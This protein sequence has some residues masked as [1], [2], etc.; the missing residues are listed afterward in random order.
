MDNHTHGH[1]GFP[2]AGHIGH[3]HRGRRRHPQRGR[4]HSRHDGGPSGFPPGFAG[5]G[6]AGFG[7]DGPAFGRGRGRGG[8]GR[9]GDVRAAILLLLAE[10]P[11]HG[12]Q[13][14]QQI[15]ERSEGVWKPSSGS[16]YPALAQLE[17]EGLVLIEKVAG[18]KTAR[19]TEDGAQYVETNKADLGVPWDDVRGAAGVVSVDLRSAISALMGAASQVAAVGTPGQQAR[20]IEVLA[21]ARRALYRVLSEEVPA[22]DAAA[23]GRDTEGED[24]SAGGEAAEGVD[25]S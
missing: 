19:L 11:M 5:P 10:E 23:E 20:G 18:R 9:R 17:D 14:I 25:A 16:I 3:D 1:P 21:D 13:L 4:R 8:R 7:P 24:K 15:V 6:F 2:H 12:Y 22:E